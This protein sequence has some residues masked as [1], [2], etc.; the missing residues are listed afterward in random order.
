MFLS[1]LQ[2]NFN[3]VDVQQ[4]SFC[5]LKL[6]MDQN[7]FRIQIWTGNR[8]CSGLSRKQSKASLAYPTGFTKNE[9]PRMHQNF[10]GELEPC[11]SSLAFATIIFKAMSQFILNAN[12]CAWYCER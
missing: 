2:R 4:S 3:C 9:M 12:C 1:I 10:S 6:F 7:S 8:S 5:R 11:D